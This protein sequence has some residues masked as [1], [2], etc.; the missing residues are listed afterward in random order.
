MVDGGV[1]GGR[2]G[3]RARGRFFAFY[4]GFFCVN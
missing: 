1:R 2:A 3:R 4:I